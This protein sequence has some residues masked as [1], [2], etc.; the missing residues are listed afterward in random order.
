MSFVTIT[1]CV[2]SQRVFIVIVYFVI[3]SFQKL[4]DIPFYIQSSDLVFTMLYV[5]SIAVCIFMILSITI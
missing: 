5:V 2:A 4:L 1:L 3:N